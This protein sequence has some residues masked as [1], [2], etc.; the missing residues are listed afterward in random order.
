MKTENTCNWTAN[1]VL[2]LSG[3]GPEVNEKD[4][5]FYWQHMLL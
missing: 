5:P 3:C 2:F 4:V 1:D